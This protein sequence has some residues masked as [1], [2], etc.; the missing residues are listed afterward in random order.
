VPGLC[1]IERF[2][3][4]A[5]STPDASNGRQTLKGP[6]RQFKMSASCASYTVDK[7]GLMKKCALE[8]VI[9]Q[10]FSSSDDDD[11]SAAVEGEKVHDK[12]QKKPSKK[13]R[14]PNSNASAWSGSDV[15]ID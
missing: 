15:E 1:S 5:V 7:K 12:K 2:V 14:A 11:V 4:V 3:A 13:S 8:K 9:A 6:A 10:A